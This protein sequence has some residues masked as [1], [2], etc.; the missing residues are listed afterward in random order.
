MISELKIGTGVRNGIT[1]LKESYY[2]KPFKL[3]DIGVY[4]ADKA[5]CLMLMTASPGMLNG[6]DYRITINVSAGARL[7]LQTQAYQ[8]LYSM[9]TGARQQMDVEVGEKALFSYVPHPIVPHTDAVFEGHNRI[10]L[11]EGSRLIWGEILTCGR[12][13]NGE[14]FKFRLFHNL[15]ELRYKGKLILKDNVMIQPARLNVY[16]PGEMEGFTHQATLIY[17]DTRQDAPPVADRL[18]ELLAHEEDIAFGVTQSAGPAI[19]LRI[20]GHGAEQLFNCMRSMETVLWTLS[21]S[22]SLRGV[23]GISAWGDEAIS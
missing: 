9:Q 7:Q 4:R 8:R 6:D 18:L 2:T 13:L 3:A 16:E 1:Y 10:N 14:V 19:V 22:P 5:L 20:L 21:P 17:A 12:K 11:S 15:T 23:A